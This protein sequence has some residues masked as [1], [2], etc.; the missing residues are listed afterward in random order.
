MNLEPPKIKSL[1]AS[2]VSTMDIALE[3]NKN[4]IQRGKKSTEERINEFGDNFKK[5][6]RRVM[7]E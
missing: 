2:V 3:M 4:K 6:G 1:P 7:R 5:L